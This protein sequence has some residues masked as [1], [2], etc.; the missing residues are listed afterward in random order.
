M[1]RNSCFVVSFSSLALKAD[2]YAKAFEALESGD[3]ETATYY[4]SFFASNGDSVSQYNM[5]ILIV[6]A[7]VLKQIPKSLSHGYTSR[8]I[9]VICCQTSR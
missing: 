1:R 2:D 9:K 7:W 8:L 5:G 6:M 3:Y 4:L